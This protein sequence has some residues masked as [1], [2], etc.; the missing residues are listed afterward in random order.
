LGKNLVSLQTSFSK[1]FNALARFTGAAFV[2]AGVI[3]IVIGIRDHEKWSAV[4]GIFAGVIGILL[5]V[6]K[7]P[8][9]E[10]KD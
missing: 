3:F 7:N 1:L 6:A 9:V 5:L 2:V 10:N 8:G 4:V